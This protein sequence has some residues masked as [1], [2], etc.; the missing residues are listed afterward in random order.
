[1]VEHPR[2]RAGIL[3]GNPVHEDMVEQAKMAN[4]NF[5]VNVLLN[6][7]RQITHIFAGDP[8]KAH[9]AG[10][11]TA[12]SIVGVKVPR[13]VD[14]TITTNNGAPLDLDLYQTCKG[15]ET[16]SQITRDGGVI[17]SSA[18]CNT[19]IG[20]EIF[21]KVHASVSSPVEVLQKIK[22]EE[23]IGVQW[24]N[25]ILARI[26]LK[27]DIYLFSCLAD[28]MV[29]D[30]MMVPIRSVE[31]G[32]TEAFKLLGSEAEVAVIPEGPL[33]LPLLQN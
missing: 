4:L 18:A 17:I 21:R 33:V 31:G 27:H 7:E 3:K 13:M 22:R 1:M 10:C 28:N 2:V 25:Q 24:Q 16:A 9:E 30:M 8:F 32:L 23:P 5:I 20:P 6:K 19:G 15:I 29:K 14:I 26:Q 12:R 11:E